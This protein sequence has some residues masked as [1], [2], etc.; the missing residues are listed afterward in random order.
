MKR[1]IRL[2]FHKLGFTVERLKRIRIAHLELGNLV[3]G[4]WRVLP[5]REVCKLE[6]AS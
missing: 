3:P 6:A 1:Q 2:M 4:A 5:K